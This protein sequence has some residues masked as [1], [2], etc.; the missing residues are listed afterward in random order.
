MILILDFN[1]N[2]HSI[3][4]IHHKYNFS[5]TYLVWLIFHNLKIKIRLLSAK[6]KSLISAKILLREFNL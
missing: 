5:V 1:K 6:S 2:I 3:K 4:N